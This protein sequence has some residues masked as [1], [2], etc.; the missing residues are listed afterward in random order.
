MGINL[1]QFVLTCHWGSS[2]TGRGCCLGCGRGCS[3]HHSTEMGSGGLDLKHQHTR[4]WLN[5]FYNIFVFLLKSDCFCRGQKQHRNLVGLN[6]PQVCPGP[7]WH[8]QQGLWGKSCSQRGSRQDSSAPLYG[9]SWDLRD[10][11]EEA[12]EDGQPQTHNNCWPS[13]SYTSYCCRFNHSSFI[14]KQ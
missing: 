10:A 9:Q 6:L 8:W 14:H 12:E 13:T 11:A 5:T 3:S 7:R 1:L 2:G 4:F